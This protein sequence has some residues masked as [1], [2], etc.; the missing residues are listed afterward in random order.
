MTKAVWASILFATSIGGAG[1]A[2]ADKLDEVISSGVLRCAVV[3]DFPPMGYREADGTPAGFDVDYCADLAAALDVKPEIVETA[4]SDRIAALISNRAD[5]IVGS[6]SD[7]LERAKVVGFSVPYFVFQH[8]LLT[9]KDSDISTWDDAKG[10]TIGVISGSYEAMHLEST[11]NDWA[12]E[13]R[14]YQTQNDVILAVEQGHVDAS[15]S[16]SSVVAA[17]INSGD[18]GNLKMGGVVPTPPD[19][20]ALAAARHEYGFID[21][22]SLFVN[23]QTRT[24]RYQE[25]YTKYY[26]TT[27]VPSLV[28]PDVYR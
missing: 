16:V 25:L 11:L 26:H 20:S 6:T 19:F 23:Q 27:D 15:I 9:P 2:N 12:G 1:I 5:V 3:L 18:F 8:V 21:Y 28:V 7:T 24:G 22:L 10:K 13:V 17:S 4:M 14:Y